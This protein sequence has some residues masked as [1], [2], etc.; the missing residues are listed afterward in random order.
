M[1]KTA[2][3]VKKVFTKEQFAAW[4]QARVENYAR[5]RSLGALAQ[6]LVELEDSSECL[7]EFEIDERWPSA[8]EHLRIR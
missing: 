7:P 5:T 4:R 6:M 2:K 8:V 1:A 3:T